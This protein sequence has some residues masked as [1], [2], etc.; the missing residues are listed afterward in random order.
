M[1]AKD[2]HRVC[3]KHNLFKT[4]SVSTAPCENQRPPEIRDGM[5]RYHGVRHNDK[6][7]Y[8]CNTGFKLVGDHF[9]TCSYGQWVGQK[10]YCDPGGVHA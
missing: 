4:T 1:S 9:M 6:A 2:P 10:P 7:K 5:V 3:N 8:R